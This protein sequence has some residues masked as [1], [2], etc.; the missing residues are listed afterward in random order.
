MFLLLGSV[1]CNSGTD[2]F[3]TGFSPTFDYESKNL[4]AL[5]EQLRV[6]MVRSV[7]GIWID[8]QLRLRHVLGH[9]AP[10]WTRCVATVAYV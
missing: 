1:K 5:Q 10:A 3:N 6:L 7:P 2:E 8:D 9:D 4:A